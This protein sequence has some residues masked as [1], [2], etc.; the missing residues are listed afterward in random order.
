M[1]RFLPEVQKVKPCVSIATAVLCT[2]SPTYQL[3][4]DDLPAEWFPTIITLIFCRGAMHE[5]PSFEQIGMM[6]SC[7]GRSSDGASRGSY[8]FEPA[9]GLPSSKVYL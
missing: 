7:F 5:S 3:M 4:Y 1:S 8:R 6:P 9:S 2:C